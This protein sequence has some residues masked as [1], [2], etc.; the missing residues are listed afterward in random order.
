MNIRLVNWHARAPNGVFNPSSK[1]K[2]TRIFFT[3]FADGHNVMALPNCTYNLGPNLAFVHP[4]FQ[5]LQEDVLNCH[6]N[7]K[8]NYLY[9]ETNRVTLM[10]ENVTQVK[11]SIF[12]Y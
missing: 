7:H 12:M 6:Y 1:G 10:L 3:T 5:D 9:M 4:T 2:D 8:E 11:V